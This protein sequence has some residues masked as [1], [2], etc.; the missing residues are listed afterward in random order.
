MM[1]PVSRMVVLGGLGQVGQLITDSFAPTGTDVYIVDILKRPLNVAAER[2]LQVNVTEP[3]D[4]L[5]HLIGSAD[6]VILSLPQ[7][8]TV[9]ASGA[10]LEAMSEKSLWVDTSSVKQELCQLLKAYEG[11]REILSLNPMFAPSLPFDGQVMAVIEFSGGP[12]SKWF[13]AKLQSLGVELEIMT[14]ETHDNL[15]GAIQIA[16]HAAVVSFGVALARLGYNVTQA[17]TIATPPHLLLVSLLHRIVYANPDVYWEIQHHHPYATSVRK[18]L[19]EALETLD[20]AAASDSSAEFQK[21]FEE[22]RLVLAPRQG[23]LSKLS[24]AF[25]TE[26]KNSR[27]LQIERS[28]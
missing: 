12:K 25:V 14:A 2:Y 28:D 16:T 1:N 22:L 8:T 15:T 23:L 7:H 11:R 19:F 10:V 4:S 9:A 3:S 20:S 27:R 17:L 21:L 13:C 24:E 5:L 18:E 6:C 26:T